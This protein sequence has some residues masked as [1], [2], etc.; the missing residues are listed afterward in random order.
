MIRID[1]DEQAITGFVTRHA[2]SWIQKLLLVPTEP[3]SMREI[4]GWREARRL[5][6]NALIIG[7]GA[8]SLALMLFFG[9]K[10]RLVDYASCAG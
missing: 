4:I 3:Q 2:P 9:R 1:I 7:C 6:Y 10:K 5:L 8:A